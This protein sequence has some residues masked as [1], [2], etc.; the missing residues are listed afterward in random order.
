MRNIIN[1]FKNKKLYLSTLAMTFIFNKTAYAN[2]PGDPT[3]IGEVFDKLRPD[4]EELVRPASAVLIFIA[5]LSLGINIII[6]RNKPGE[7]SGVM[8]GLVGVAAGAFILGCAG[9]IY[10][11]IMGLTA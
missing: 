7:R 6:T 5:V 11:F 1:T 10:D 3:K 9:L 8:M 2:D 4:I